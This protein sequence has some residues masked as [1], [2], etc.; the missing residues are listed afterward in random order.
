MVFG[1]PETSDLVVGFMARYWGDYLIS[2]FIYA[3]PKFGVWLNETVTFSNRVN[4]RLEST[5]RYPDGSAQAPEARKS[6]CYEFKSLGERDH[7]TRD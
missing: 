5:S 7:I 4:S 3:P 1:F 6:F 2:N